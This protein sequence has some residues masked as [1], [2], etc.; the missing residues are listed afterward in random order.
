MYLYNKD[1]IETQQQQEAS[2]FHLEIL[3]DTVRYYFLKSTRHS[4]SGGG[5]TAQQRNIQLSVS[6]GL[7]SCYQQ[8][9]YGT[10]SARI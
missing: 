1:D 5:H 7:P 3:A 4:P 2:M 10:A 8:P 9:E 6:Y